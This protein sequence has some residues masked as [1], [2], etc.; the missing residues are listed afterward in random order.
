MP[1]PILNQNG[2]AEPRY[3]WAAIEPRFDLQ[4]ALEGAIA[5]TLTPEQALA[6]AQKQTDDWLAKQAA[7]SSN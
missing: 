1:T 2:N 6:Q 4:A 3:P 7:P 5:G